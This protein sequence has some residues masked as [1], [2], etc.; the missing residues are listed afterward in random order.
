MIALLLVYG[1]LAYFSHQAHLRLGFDHD[2]VVQRGE[3]RLGTV[4]TGFTSPP[5]PRGQDEEETI[6][7]LRSHYGIEGDKI[8]NYR[9]RDDLLFFC[10]DSVEP[11]ECT[12]RNGFTFALAYSYQVADL[13]L[14][15]IWNVVF[16]PVEHGQF[17]RD[18]VRILY[19]I[20]LG[21]AKVAVLLASADWGQRA[22]PEPIGQLNG[23][24][25]TSLAR[26]LESLANEADAQ[27]L[28]P[29]GLRLEEMRI[30]VIP[31]HN[32]LPGHS[33]VAALVDGPLADFADWVG[34]EGDGTEMFNRIVQ[35]CAA[36]ALLVGFSRVTWGF[37][38]FTANWRREWQA[39]DRD[40]KLDRERLS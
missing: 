20:D 16:A 36:L 8:S 33:H 28:N 26:R 19:R 7:A 4:S 11:A 31:K 12:V 29:L 30:L 39:L 27:A 22:L 13:V 3:T 35:L 5:T 24:D 6:A 17:T 37:L 21:G 34:A 32:P 23:F 1:V 40:A 2:Y 14:R 15:D 38:R 10:P 25:E 18:P 9:W